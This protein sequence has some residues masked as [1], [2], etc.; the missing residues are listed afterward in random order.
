MYKY[1]RLSGEAANTHSKVW[2]DLIGVNSLS[3]QYLYMESVV[4]LGFDPYQVKPDFR[5]SIWCFFTKYAV[6]VHVECG[7]LT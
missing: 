1:C 2:F 5:M 3:I 7:S 6:F 4:D